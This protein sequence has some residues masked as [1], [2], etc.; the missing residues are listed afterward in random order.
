MG[1][2]DFV[3]KFGVIGEN[4]DTIRNREKDEH[5]LSS[6]LTIDQNEV[7]PRI[8]MN[9]LLSDARRE[10]NFVYPMSYENYERHCRL[11]GRIP[12]SREWAKS[13]GVHFDSD[14]CA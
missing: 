12:D 3:K 8:D 9:D 6:V 4:L 2:F 14:D 7:K 10:S 1:I 13:H 11:N 5:R